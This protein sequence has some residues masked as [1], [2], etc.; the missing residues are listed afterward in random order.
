MAPTHLTL[1]P[2]SAAGLPRQSSMKKNNKTPNADGELNLKG[3]A[4]QVVGAKSTTPK[5]QA[6]SETFQHSLFCDPSVATPKSIPSPM[7]SATSPS[8][9]HLGPIRRTSRTRRRSSPIIEGPDFVGEH[10]AQEDKLSELPR[11]THFG[12][13]TPPRRSLSSASQRQRLQ[14]A[15]ISTQVATRAAHELITPVDEKDAVSP[16]PDKTR[17]RST[18]PKQDYNA[19]AR[20]DSPARSPGFAPP[21]RSIFPQYDPS[22]PL[23]H[24]SY[25]P[26]ARVQ[27]PPAYHSPV[28]SSIG[29]PIQRQELKRYDSAVGLVDGYEHIPAAGHADLEALWKASIESYPCDGRKVQY[30]LYQATSDPS[31]KLAVGTSHEDVMYSMMR[32]STSGTSPK[33]YALRKHCPTAPCSSPVSELV[34]PEKSEDPRAKELEVTTIFPQTAAMAAIEAVADSPRARNIA[35][36]DPSAQSAEAARLAQDAVAEAHQEY[37]CDLINKSRKRDALS[38]TVEAHYDLKH[39]QLGVC[40]ITVTKS[41]RSTGG[42]AAKISFH[43]PSATPAAV[44]ADTLNLAFLDFSHDACV[45]DLPGLLALDS[46]FVVDTVVSALLAVAVIENEAL[47]REQITFAAPPVQHPVAGASK[48]KKKSSNATKPSRRSSV[49]STAS[50]KTNFLA[51]RKEKKEI[52]EMVAVQPPIKEEKEEFPGFT[53]AVFGLVGLGIKGSWWVAKTSVKVAVKGVK[54]ARKSAEGPPDLR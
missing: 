51:R 36:F 22:R 7:S 24:Q 44:S 48:D 14:P 42:A 35:T 4:F 38:S 49:S 34:L 1:F 9:T 11:N 13:T 10:I 8:T 29:S 15:N 25:Y 47:V 2:S 23:D 20:T 33:R 3:V 37:A 16:L 27:S 45:L 12:S 39:P 21:M 40:A 43:H 32:Q 53:R 26:T 17:F 6:A 19:S 30:N 52:K 46:R 50:S 28:A 31:I 54:M 41:H 18:S 5:I